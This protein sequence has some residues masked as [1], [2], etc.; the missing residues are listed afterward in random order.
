MVRGDRQAALWSHPSLR[1]DD[2]RDGE[3]VDERH[4]AEVD[5]DPCGPGVGRRAQAAAQFPRGADVHLA[6][7]LEGAALLPKGHFDG[8]AL[9]PGT[10]VVTVPCA[11]DPMRGWTDGQVGPRA[12]PGET[13]RRPARDRGSASAR[14]A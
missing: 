14:G 7:N 11:P 1:P 3:R 9:A 8:A 13:G 12:F 10:H 2:P 4:V 6:V 5:E